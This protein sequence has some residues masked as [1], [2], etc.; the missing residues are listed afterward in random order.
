MNRR[1]GGGRSRGNWSAVLAITAMSGCGA[2]RPSAGVSPPVEDF[3]VKTAGLISDQANSSGK[4]GFTWIAPMVVT[5]PAGF[6]TLDQT[7]VANG[8][9][10]KVDRLFA[11]NSTS[12]TTSF[13]GAGI[14][15]FTGTTA[16]ATFGGATGPFYG[17]NWAAG[18]TVAIG[19]TYRVSIQA[20]TNPTR[21]LG[22][23]DVQVVADATAAAAVD[24]TKFKPLIRGTSLP[25]VFRL[26][27]KDTDGDTVNNWRDNCVFTKNFNQLDVDADGVGNACQCLNVANGKA[28]NTSSCK[29]GETCQSGTCTGGTATNTGGNCSTG[30]PCMSNEKC[31]AAGVCGGAGLQ[32]PRTSGACS[33]GNPCKMNEACN[34]SS[35]CTGGSNSPTTTACVSGNSC[36]SN[37]FCNAGA[38]GGAGH[39]TLRTSG[40]CSTGNPCRTGEQCSTASVCGGGAA[41]Q[42]GTV[43]S[44]GDLCTPADTCQAG[45]C[46]P[47]AAIACSTDTKCHNAGSCNRTLG[48]CPARKADATACNTNACT[49]GE[50]CQAGACVGG[51]AVTCAAPDDCHTVAACVPATGCPAPVAKA[52]NTACNDQN[53]CTQ[54]DTCRAGVCGGTQIACPGDS[55][56]PAG[57]CSPATGL[58]SVPA[59]VADGTS[60]NDGNGC[61]TQ[62]ACQAGS[63]VPEDPVTGCTAPLA[64]YYAPLV[65]LGSSQGASYAWN[66]NEAGQVIGAD[67]H[68]TFLNTGPGPGA[69]AGFRWSNKAASQGGGMI[70]LP[71]PAGKVLYPR[72][73][74]SA[75]VIAGTAVDPAG[76]WSAFRFDPATPGQTEILAVPTG[77]ANG[78]NDG[79]QIAG[80]GYFA[81]VPRMYRAVGATIETLL[82]PPGE[83]FSQA[84]AIDSAGS[85]VGYTYRA[86]TGVSAMRYTNARGPEYLSQLLPAGSDWNLDPVIGGDYLGSGYGSNETQIVGYGYTGNGLTRGFVLTPGPNGSPGTI[87]QVGLPASY[88]SN[89]TFHAVAINDINANGEAVGAVYDGSLSLGETAIMWVDG[90]GTIS[91]ND[92]VD[93]GSGWVLKAAYAINGPRREV[94]GYGYLNGQQRAFKM[95]VPNMSPCP[96][97]DACHTALRNLRTGVCPAVT[98]LADG[99]ACNDGNACTG[100]D[101]CQSGS[102]I[103]GASALAC[104]ITPEFE[105]IAE[106]GS[107]AWAVFGYSNVASANINI[108]Y[109]AENGFTDVNGLIASPQTPPPEW[110]LSGT[111]RAVL[112]VPMTAGTLTW[113]VRTQS[114]TANFS[115]ARIPTADTPRGPVATL[116]DGTK[117]LLDFNP[118]Y[119]IVNADVISPSVVAGKMDGALSVTADGAASYRIPLWTPPGR[120]GTEPKLALAYNSRQGTGRLGVGWALEGMSQITRCEKNVARDQ[121]A[122]EPAFAA[123][124]A[125]CLDGK[126]LMRV[127][128]VGGDGSEYWD[129]ETTFTKVIQHGD[130]SSATSFDAK[131]RDGTTRKYGGGNATVRPS[132][133]SSAELAWALAERRDKGGSAVKYSYRPVTFSDGPDLEYVIDSIDYVFSDSGETTSTR[134]VVFQYDDLAKP[135]NKRLWGYTK[136]L[137]TRLF[138]ISMI[139]PNPSQPGTLKSYRMTYDTG[140][141]TGR[142]RLTSVTECDGVAVGTVCKRPTTLYYSDDPNPQYQA[143]PGWFSET[144]FPVPGKSNYGT[145]SFRGPAMVA[146]LNGDGLDDVVNIYYDNMFVSNLL[147][148]TFNGG[149]IVC[150]LS[151][152]AT[153][154]PEI[155]LSSQLPATIGDLAIYM[156]DVDSDGKTDLFIPIASYPVRNTLTDYYLFRNVSSR[157]QTSSPNAGLQFVRDA[158]PY[159]KV[160]PNPNPPNSSPVFQTRPYFADADG[161]GLVDLLQ[162]VAVLNPAVEN[163]W[164]GIQWK[165][166]KGEPGGVLA[167]PLNMAFTTGGFLTNPQWG[168]SHDTVVATK[169][170]QH[171]GRQFLI[172]TGSRT[173]NV[174]GATLFRNVF[175]AFEMK[176]FADQVVATDPKAFD[177][178]VPTS[179]TIDMNGDGLPEL[180]KVNT[181]AG[182]CVEQPP[183]GCITTQ[184][185][186]NIILADNMG[187]EFSPDRFSAIQTVYP[188]S[189]YGAWA[190]DANE[191][192]REDL[193]LLEDSRDNGVSQDWGA[194]N[195]TVHDSTGRD[196]NPAH[197]LFDTAGNRIKSLYHEG[198]TT[199]AESLELVPMAALADGAV[200]GA[201][202]LD[203]NGDGLTDIVIGPNLYVRQ[204]TRADMLTGVVDGLGHDTLVKYRPLGDRTPSI[205]GNPAPFYA[206]TEESAYPQF[207][208]DK[209]MWAVSEVAVDDGTTPRNQDPALCTQ[210]GRA[211]VGNYN[212]TFYAYE[213]GRSSLING[214]WLGFTKR[215]AYDGSRGTLETTKFETT[216]QT[217]PGTYWGRFK[218]TSVEVTTVLPAHDTTI[219]ANQD[220]SYRHRT[221]YVYRVFSPFDLRAGFGVYIVLPTSITEDE[222]ET[223]GGTVQITRHD[224]TTLVY[225]EFANVTSRTVSHLD[226]ESQI[227]TTVPENR[228]TNGAWLLGLPTTVTRVSTPLNGAPTQTQVVEHTYDARGFLDTE[229][230]EPAGDS[231]LFLFRKMG[232]GSFGSTIWINETD[233]AG[234]SRRTD[235]LFDALEMY[236]ARVRNGL[237]H[238]TQTSFHP[239]YGL[240]VFTLDANGALSA[241]RYDRFGRQ[242]VTEAPD[243]SSSQ[244]TY[245]LAAD[246]SKAYMALDVATDGGTRGGVFDRLGRTV[247]TLARAPD[248]RMSHALVTYDKL[249]YVV[250][251]L[252]PAFD[253][254]ASEA[255]V[256][257]SYDVRG[258]VTKRAR[259]RNDNGQV[260]DDFSF[261]FGT[262][263]VRVDPLVQTDSGLLRP[264]HSIVSDTL[265]RALSVAD[266]KD[267]TG[268]NAVTTAFSYGAFG[269]LQQVQMPGV[270]ATSRTL[271]YD[272]LGRRISE[273]D[274]DSGTTSYTFDA[275]G[276]IASLTDAKNQTTVQTSDAL[277]RPTGEQSVLGA[278][279]IVWDQA[280]FGIGKPGLAVSAVGAGGAA[281]R[282][283][284]DSGAHPLRESWNIHGRSFDIDYSYVQS[285][286]QIGKLDHVTYPAVPGVPSRFT[287]EQRYSPVSGNLVSIG[288]PGGTGA[289]FTVNARDA[290]L[291]VTQETF[292]SDLGRTRGYDP[293]SGMLASAHAVLG[294]TV[295][296]DLSLAYDGRM[297]LKSRIEHANSAQS[298]SG[299]NDAFT[300]DVLGRLRRWDSTTGA[301]GVEYQ[302][303]DLGNLTLRRVSG[304][305]IP[306]SDSVFRFAES[307][308]GPH[309][310]TSAPWGS[311]NYDANGD[312]VTAP[313]RTVNF[314]P[315]HL[316]LSITSATQATQLEYDASHHRVYKASAAAGTTY[317]GEVYE[318]RS[319]SGS[320]Q[321]IFHLSVEGRN[322]ADIAIDEAAGAQPAVTYLLDDHLGSPVVIVGGD[323]QVSR[324]RFEPF[325]QRLA[326]GETPNAGISGNL[327]VHQG[328]TGHEH[329]DEFGLINMKGRLYDPRTGRFL[330][331]DPVVSDPL[332]TQSYNRYSYVENNPLSLRDPSGFDPR[333]GI[334]ASPQQVADLTSNSEPPTMDV[335]RVVVPRYDDLGGQSVVIS[336]DR[337]EESSMREVFGQA[338]ATR[339]LAQ[340]TNSAQL[341]APAPISAPIIVPG[342]GPWGFL[343]LPFSDI[344]D[345]SDPA[346]QPKGSEP[347]E[348]KGPGVYRGMRVGPNGLPAIGPTKKSLG[349]VP[350]P[351]ENADILVNG[352]IVKPGTG[353]MSVALITP[354]NLKE[355]RRPPEWGGTSK[356]PVWGINPA[357]IVLNPLLNLVPDGPT[358]GTIEPSFEMSIGDY[359]KALG[360]TAPL[361]QL[362]PAPR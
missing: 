23:A 244:V 211:G 55:C 121:I 131:L 66:I 257:I 24:R 233:R 132:S 125:L 79:G 107:S 263:A 181:A 245:T 311:F 110:F 133:T 91:L 161:D 357:L 21:V 22:V 105:G 193:V 12:A 310:V 299:S 235:I 158:Q 106:S 83:T 273:T 34:A 170:H 197:Y 73:I 190:M 185:I 31:S 174:N 75:G 306:Q 198:A 339:P 148:K 337:A 191:D 36:A 207:G 336:G 13:T 155:D 240:P 208:V 178:G 19:E 60:C 164:L 149:H 142:D 228:T 210:C 144:T 77:N 163:T 288:P 86:G 267:A 281:V 278:S 251:A 223:A 330:S 172:P 39:A 253:G 8:L 266:Y 225:D 140:A 186:Q 246:L 259:R 94:V 227:E 243:G 141:L 213:N 280:P 4:G 201:T 331:P 57:T 85:L 283:A 81:G 217:H 165:F 65:N 321:H 333:G 138:R 76:N 96:G 295:L 218:P 287:V 269:Y 328:L 15:M 239:G 103:G 179:M 130:L 351:G 89:D 342:L 268:T 188:G 242:K 361:W 195:I 286:P 241:I 78:I 98:A 338:E 16:N 114:A 317:V 226:A 28:C 101:T 58:C 119:G 14:T 146:D 47:G 362:V 212:R 296:Q 11:D 35:V 345:S 303:D 102:C 5:T 33:T 99:T 276:A 169:L 270:T 320:V 199:I 49:T 10:I 319:E 234:K 112:A 70:A 316:P 115:G 341:I 52:D 139:G 335:V 275:W 176:N 154:G 354:L 29:T 196:F 173:I 220:V 302:Y 167:P 309:Q 332:L 304:T 230:V 26:E 215:S 93:P 308:H 111:H 95:H 38:C 349:V 183:V 358:H 113:N 20:L 43:C 1:F 68:A 301:F 25:I 314:A 200:H 56:R 305:G 162:G 285:G 360:N 194:R 289:Y 325:G 282:Y 229:T 344:H 315:F 323:G 258:R 9:T 236:P 279:Q 3:V 312:Q 356:D 126:R 284:Y 97:V 17:A 291:R 189:G 166:S 326:L 252:N 67:A 127:A 129:S 41:A 340:D 249:G 50:A 250:T 120:N 109:G 160:Q 271:T 18:T 108:P 137:A 128:G 353:G 290:T 145:T 206:R 2:G 205:P 348:R 153:L 359:Q 224:Q 61:T 262:Q 248:G 274:S 318:R 124:D 32:T 80:Y 180:V 203:V 247:D 346:R 45:L 48:V 150:R 72:G 221:D 294:G 135:E 168:F 347:R 51:T 298:P 232:H 322:V 53:A 30:N 71:P 343:L 74:N 151:N 27:S 175:G 63:C 350:G 307:G 238:V 231:S 272:R 237:G 136:R 300:Y 334:G 92:L 82:G 159:M 187:K 329:D 264:S 42:A 46:T 116:P 40:A 171:S 157:V 7:G 261:Y 123:G 222:S 202:P 88:G 90:T 214:D 87:K 255:Q 156:T 69:V 6:T 152:G 37:E 64:P 122:D 147:G 100:G 219:R 192:G 177:D 209:G 265:G 297:S 204:G 182:V 292:G 117:L 277:G 84:N 184:V 104:T 54:G 260:V 59:P 254:S 143:I 134:R 313:E 352:G 118:G 216:Q 62:E 293:I 324:A 355:W 44:D 256:D 327:Q